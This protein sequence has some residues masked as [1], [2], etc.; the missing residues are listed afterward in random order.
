MHQYD[1]FKTSTWIQLKQS[2][3]WN[4]VQLYQQLLEQIPSL[5][6]NHDI[7]KGWEEYKYR[8]N[9]DGWRYLKIGKKLE[10]R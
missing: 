10:Y 7:L 9:S 6:I 1:E 3:K 8:W 4:N 5:A 2:L